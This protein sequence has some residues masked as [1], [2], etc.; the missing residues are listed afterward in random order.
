MRRLMIPLAALVISSCTIADVLS[1]NV[2]ARAGDQVLTVDWFAETVADGRAVLRPEALERW[3]W[4]WVEYSL[5]LQAIADGETFADSAT[6]EEVM[7]PE[8]LFTRVAALHEEFTERRAQLDSAQVDSAFAA[9][10]QRIIDHILIASAPSDTPSEKETKRLRAEA[11]RDRLLAGGSWATEAQ[12]TDDVAT[13]R[14]NGRLGIIERGETVPEFEQV[15][16]SLGPGELSPVTETYYGFHILRRPPLAEVREEYAARISV[17]M[18][19]QRRDALLRELTERKS[20]RVNDDGPDI[21]RAAAARPVR[22]LA[23]APGKVIGTYDGGRLTDVDF[24]RWLQAWSGEMPI[25]VE[26]TSD[27]ALLDMAMKA[28]QNEILH[29]EAKEVGVE[30]PAEQEV[31]IRRAL[32]SRLQRVRRVLGL[33]SA[34][35]QVEELGARMQVAREVLDAY[36]KR[37]AR[38]LR[39]VVMVPPFLAAK[40]RSERPWSFSY[41]GLNKA[42][43]QAVELRAARDSSSGQM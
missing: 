24:V 25:A 15:V 9:G 16:F 14:R 33:D 43:R 34:M 37:T 23:R 30:I 13:R 7:W 10:D 40:L 2:V 3:A 1:R 32:E 22:V 19:D 35:A 8:L 6:V 26:D 41:A 5:F 21:M 39:E 42:I 17:V 11:I 36:K 12:A 18:M 31:R 29:S 27:D 28:M 4:S 20:V 38:N